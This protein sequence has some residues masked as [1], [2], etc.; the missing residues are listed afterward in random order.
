MIF[1]DFKK[2]Y[3]CMHRE[4]LISILEQYGLLL[5]LVNLIKASTMNTEIK[6]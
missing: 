2:A 4:S 6:V 3:D 5:K 1:I